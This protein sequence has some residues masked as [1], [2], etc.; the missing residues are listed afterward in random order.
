MSADPSD[1][2][3]EE[4]VARLLREFEETRRRSQE[5]RKSV[6]DTIERARRT[7]GGAGPSPATDDPPADGEPSGRAED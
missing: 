5:I 7:L 2:P 6:Q 3:F 1:P 4:R